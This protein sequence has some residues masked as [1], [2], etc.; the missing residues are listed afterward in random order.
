MPARCQAQTSPKVTSSTLH[1]P[2]KIGLL[3][4]L[5]PI[6]ENGC[7]MK[8]QSPLMRTAADLKGPGLRRRGA[9]SGSSNPLARIRSTTI[10]DTWRTFHVI[11]VHT[12]STTHA[13]MYMHIRIH[14]HVMSI[15]F[16]IHGM[17]ALSIQLCLRARCPAGGECL[18]ESNSQPRQQC[19]RRKR[20]AMLTEH[21]RVGHQL[22]TGA[23]TFVH[24]V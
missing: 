1:L 6:W 21:L 17:Y 8:N 16:F 3:I 19:R 7:R 18:N 14:A 23:L 10:K 15:S 22:E 5:T 12:H 24:A 2:S 13:C 11:D 4:R 20:R 9:R